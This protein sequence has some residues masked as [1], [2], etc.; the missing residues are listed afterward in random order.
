M[1]TVVRLFYYSVPPKLKKLSVLDNFF[2]QCS[3]QV[4]H[5]GLLQWSVRALPVDHAEGD[6]LGLRG[7]CPGDGGT[8]RL[9]D[10]GNGAVAARL[11]EKLPAAVLKTWDVINC[12]VDIQPAA[13]WTNDM[14]NEAGSQ[15]G[16]GHTVYMASI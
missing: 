2:D 9:H 15:T 13:E 4:S 11:D 12:E 8:R 6:T 14:T 3:A 7:K 16:L 1:L 5:F 10:D